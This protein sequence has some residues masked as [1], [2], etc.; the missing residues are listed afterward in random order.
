LTLGQA[1]GGNIEPIK[2]LK[3]KWAKLLGEFTFADVINE[4]EK[5]GRDP[6]D[7]FKI[8]KYRDDVHEVKD[9]KEGMICPGLVTNVT[10]FGAFVDIGVHQDGLVHISQLTH[11]FVQDPREV[12]NPGDQVQVKVLGV[13][14]EKN[15]ISLTMLLEERPKVEPRPRAERAPRA[16]RPER[17]RPR[18][19]ENNKDARGR[20]DRNN[21][22][23]A[24]R[25]PPPRGGQGQDRDRNRDQNRRPAPKPFNNPFAAAL[26]DIKNKN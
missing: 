23:N 17:P 1:L 8:F 20:G 6:R 3:E 26:A 19:N 15:Q 4:L 25:G 7:P 22:R 14:S 12:V 11:K 10:N 9:L 24:R 18:H 16:E 21:D 13:D 2:G 5:P